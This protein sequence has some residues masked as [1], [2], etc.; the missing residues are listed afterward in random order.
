MYA[1][2]HNRFM[3]PFPGLPGWA[4]ARRNLPLD[5]MVQGETSQADTPTIWLGATPYGLISNP[6]ASSHLYAKCPSRR[7]PTQFIL[8]LMLLVGW[9]EGHPTCKNWAVR[10][11]RG[12]VSAARCKWFSYGP[13]DA[14]TTPSSLA[15]VKS[16]SLPF[17]ST[18][19]HLVLE[20]RLLNE[21]SVV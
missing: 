16:R 8:A 2:T 5:F 3:A 7:N 19:I 14:T 18:L 12:Y 21:C 1:H 15:P 17:W 13:A 6:P 10:Y 20:K 9:Q 4:N 11:W